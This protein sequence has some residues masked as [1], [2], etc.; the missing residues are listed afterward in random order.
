MLG[1]L[2]KHISVDSQDQEIFIIGFYGRCI[3]VA[4]GLFRRDLISRVHQKGCTEDEAIEI[5]FTRG[6]NLSLKEDWLEVINALARLLR[7]LLS[8][9]AKMGAL[10]AYLHSAASPTAYA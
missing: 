4:R 8:G 1:Q 10:K 9:N 6:Y 2:A 7:Y 3:Y 5:Q